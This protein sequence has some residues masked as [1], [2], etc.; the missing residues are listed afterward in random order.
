MNGNDATL[1][2]VII[3]LIWRPTGIVERGE[4][5]RTMFL[6]RVYEWRLCPLCYSE[7]GEEE[8][9]KGGIFIIDRIDCFPVHIIF[10]VVMTSVG[11]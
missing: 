6:V 7:F 8:E 2:H 11:G 1:S 10:H 4:A 5:L 9:K 3:E